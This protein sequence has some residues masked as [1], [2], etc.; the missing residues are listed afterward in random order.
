MLFS[1]LVMETGLYA[2]YPPMQRYLRFVQWHRICNEKKKRDPICLAQ[3]KTR[4]YTP[5]AEW[6]NW[7]QPTGRNP[8]RRS[9]LAS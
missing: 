5:Q 8:S 6:A 2:C 4:N 7:P 9:G 3:M 1:T